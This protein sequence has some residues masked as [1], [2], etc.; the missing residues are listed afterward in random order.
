MA[1]VRF[2]LNGEVVEARG[3]DPTRTLLEHLRGDLRRTGTKEGCAEGDCGSCTVLVGELDGQGATAWRAVNSCI[4]FVPMLDGKAVITVEGLAS[5]DSKDKP[6]P[7]QAAMVEHHGSQCGFCTPGIV[8]SLYGRAVAAKGTAA[9]VD[10]V[11]AG[12]LCRCT[13]YGAIIAAAETIAPE[14]APD[15]AEHLTALK[16]DEALSLDYDDPIAGLTRRWLAPLSVDELAATYEAHPDAVI[17][18]GAT[19]IG[20]WVTKLRKPLKTLIDIGRVEALK[21][22]AREDGWLSIGAGVRYVD[23]LEPGRALSRPRRDDAPAGLDPGAQQR[24]DRRQ[25]RQ[26]LADRRHAAGPD[27]AGRELVLRKGGARRTIPLEDFFIA[28]GKQDRAPGRVRRGGARPRPGGD[29]VQ[30]LQAVQ[31]LRPGHLG[32]VRGVQHPDR[33]RGR[34]RARIAYGG[35]AGTPKR[36][37]ACEA[38]LVGKLWN[39]ATIHAAV[40]ALAGDFTPMTDARA[41]AAYRALTAG[42][43]LRK[44]FI[45]SA[46]PDLETRVPAGGGPWLIPAPSWSSRSSSRASTPRCRTTAPCA[47]SRA[48]RSMST[49]FPSRPACSTST[50][51]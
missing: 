13:G 16:R 47:T 33:R 41:S 32:G 39:R 1:A 26:R 49:T 50:W 21:T 23:A 11:L 17:V 34:D 10:E 4:Q 7:V 42:N 38:A 44:V 35:M 5:N 27:R 18:A 6:H 3:V 48:R 31:A 20:L 22:V 25:H 28:Y 43:M 14:A 37:A 45:E 2:L 30:G 29:D 51:A 36:A 12:N 15:V 24:H 46:R 8:M 40:E 9:P 19:D